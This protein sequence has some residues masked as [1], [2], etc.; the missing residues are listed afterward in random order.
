MLKCQSHSVQKKPF[1]Q[2]L[3][4]GLG[5][6]G[7]IVT[8]G[9]GAVPAAQANPYNACTV[10]LTNAKLPAEVI[11]SGCAEA[12]HPD[13]VGTCVARIVNP[14]ENPIAAADALDACRRVRRPLELATCV[15]EI[16][17]AE[18]E[19]PMKDVLEACRRSLLP[20][21]FGQC[22]VG[23]RNKPMETKVDQGL[24]ICL[25]ATDYRKDIQ[26]RPLSDLLIPY[27]APPASSTMPINPQ[28]P[29]PPTGTVKE[30]IP[31][32]Y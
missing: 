16:R 31:Q 27:V 21:R 28:T 29:T 23:F 17:K 24:S 14:T 1:L 13:H 2:S 8:L 4:A 6:T 25:D 30:I 9:F 32:T 7:T 5:L 11:A 26:L 15:N 18:A 19:A 12:L 3:Q 20:E 10:D 22:V